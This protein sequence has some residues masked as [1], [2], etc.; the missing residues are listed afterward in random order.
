MY[1]IQSLKLSLVSGMLLPNLGSQLYC[2][3]AM[4]SPT[5]SISKPLG[6]CLWVGTSGYKAKPCSYKIIKLEAARKTFRLVKSLKVKI[7][8]LT[9]SE[10]N[11]FLFSTL[12]L[13]VTHLGFLSHTKCV[14]LLGSPWPRIVTEQAGDTQGL[15][16]LGEGA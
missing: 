13:F 5:L 2:T 11:D 8:V 15:G 14:M 12:H 7:K 10:K 6:I 1:F 3:S 4:W 16:A 9:R